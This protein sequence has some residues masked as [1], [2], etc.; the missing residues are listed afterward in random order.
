MSNLEEESLHMESNPHPEMDLS[1]DKAVVNS[2]AGMDNDAASKEAETAAPKDAQLSTKPST[3][4]LKKGLRFW[5]IVV[6][7]SFTGLLTAL[8]ATITSTALPSIIAD[9]GGG[10]LY[11]WAVNGYFLTMTALQ[12]LYGQL[13]NVFGRRWPTIAATAIFVLGGGICG[14]ASSMPMLIVGRV[15]QGAGAGGMSVLI[16]MIICDLIPL[17]QRGNYFA[18]IFGLIAL[19][20]ALGPFFGGLIVEYSTWRWVFYLNLPIGG[21]ALSLLLAFLK[22]RWNKNV[23]LA[24]RLTSIDWAGNAI[25]IAAICGVLIA[26]SWLAPYIPGRHTMFL[27]HWSL[28]WWA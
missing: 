11:I 13:A 6:A 28:A 27:F 24:T 8:E 12:P 25:F 20:T 22:V 26:L 3:T 7:L 14:G 4:G 17:R 9:L 16:E 21:V 23:K 2:S 15:I 1:R 5:M 10:D 19:G 18:I